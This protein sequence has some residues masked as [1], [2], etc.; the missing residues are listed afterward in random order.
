MGIILL[1]IAI[2]L[3]FNYAIMIISWFVS[4]SIRLIQIH[5]ILN[6]G[7]EV[8]LYDFEENPKFKTSY[9]NFN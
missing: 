3:L 4:V 7:I 9:Y 6:K 1:Y 5:D 8:D 2:N